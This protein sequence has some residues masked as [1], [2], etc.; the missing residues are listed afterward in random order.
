MC[1]RIAYIASVR[2]S[3][4]VNAARRDDS[5]LSN[6]NAWV[7]FVEFATT[8]FRGII[9]TTSIGP[10]FASLATRNTIVSEPVR[11]SPSSSPWDRAPVSREFK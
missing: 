7:Q 9:G 4:A 5:I 10:C 11:P 1:T 2:K 6:D 8:I 3:L